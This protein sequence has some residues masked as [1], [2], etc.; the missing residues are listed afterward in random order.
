MSEVNARDML[1]PR[2]MVFAKFEE[3]GKKTSLRFYQHPIEVDLTKD[4]NRKLSTIIMHQ[5]LI[6]AIRNKLKE[7]R[8]LVDYLYMTIPDWH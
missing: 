1:K 7:K 5:K 3:S 2:M 4:M 8:M 6:D